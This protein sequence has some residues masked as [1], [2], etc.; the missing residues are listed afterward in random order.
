MHSASGQVIPL[1][2]DNVLAGGGEM[3]ARMRAFDWAQTPL[4]PVESWPQ[5]LRTTVGIVLNSRYPMCI[6][7]GPQLTKLYNDS[8]RPILGTIKHPDALGQPGPHVWPEIWDMI[9]PMAEQVLTTGEA[10][11]CDDM[12]LFMRR[13]GYLEEVYFTCSYS[14]IRD[15]T[16]GIGGMF[17]AC[18]ETTARVLA[19]RRQHALRDLDARWVQPRWPRRHAAWL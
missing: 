10:A 17:C 2:A 11:W 16:G 13:N 6:F 7:W 15:E 12:L 5:S 18:T 8:F 14:P 9:G 19:E 4:G 3:G 1:A